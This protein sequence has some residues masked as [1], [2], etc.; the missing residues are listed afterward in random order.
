MGLGL[1]QLFPELLVF[2]RGQS[3]LAVADLEVVFRSGGE[4]G[5]SPEPGRRVNLRVWLL[6]GLIFRQ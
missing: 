1:P 3:E 4:P 6:S 5:H 2:L